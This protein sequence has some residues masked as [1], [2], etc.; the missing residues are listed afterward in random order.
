MQFHIIL[1]FIHKCI[2]VIPCMI[3]GLAE[4]KEVIVV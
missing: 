2:W 3:S 1:E 4:S